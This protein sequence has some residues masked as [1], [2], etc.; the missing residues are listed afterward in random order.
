MIWCEGVFGRVEKP[1]GWPCLRSA[2]GSWYGGF[3]FI[4]KVEL[5]M[6]CFHEGGAYSRLCDEIGF[7][8]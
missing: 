1:D 4:A 8:S 2:E 7:L 6:L 5:D 3:F